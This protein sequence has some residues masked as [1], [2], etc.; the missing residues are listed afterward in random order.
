[1][2]QRDWLGA[3]PEADD[4]PRT[5]GAWRATGPRANFFYGGV[6]EEAEEMGLGAD[7]CGHAAA[8]AVA[9]GALVLPPQVC[10]S[11]AAPCCCGGAARVHRGPGGR[12]GRVRVCHARDAFRARA[13]SDLALCAAPAMLSSALPA[14]ARCA[15]QAVAPKTQTLI[16][17]LTLYQGLGFGL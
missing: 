9:G 2:A 16:P 8:H 7:C 11:A 13:A 14:A 12:L 5:P 15:A 10:A 6:W 3:I 17:K 4:N 1:M